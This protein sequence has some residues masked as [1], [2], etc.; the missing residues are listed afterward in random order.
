MTPNSQ[1]KNFLNFFHKSPG[2]LLKY[3]ELLTLKDKSTTIA[4]TDKKSLGEVGEKRNKYKCN[5]K[6]VWCHR[7]KTY[8]SWWLF[9]K[10]EI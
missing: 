10:N 1:F 4:T 6:C 7:R 8:S 5:L 2:R 3:I 9:G